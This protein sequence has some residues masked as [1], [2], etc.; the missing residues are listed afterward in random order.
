MCLLTVF[1]FALAD[2]WHSR[3]VTEDNTTWKVQASLNL[4]PSAHVKD[5]SGTANITGT[6]INFNLEAKF[7]AMYVDDEGTHYWNSTW[8]NGK[9]VHVKVW[10]GGNPANDTPTKDWFPSDGDIAEQHAIRFAS[11]HFSDASTPNIVVE[12]KFK[13]WKN[14]PYSQATETITLTLPTLVYNKA[15]TLATLEVFLDEASPPHY[16]KVGDPDFNDPDN[17]VGTAAN[18]ASEG[19]TA[20]TGGA[21][22]NALVPGHANNDT[23][24]RESTSGVPRL[25]EKMCLA[26]IFFACTHG[27]TG[28]YWRSAH[29]DELWF[30]PTTSNEVKTYVTTQLGGSA[31]S[32]TDYVLGFF[33]ACDTL[34]NGPNNPRAFQLSP[35]TPVANKGY[36]GF[37][38]FVRPQLNH[39]SNEYLNEHAKKL[40]E[41]LAAGYPLQRALDRTQNVNGE[42]DGSANYKRAQ[43]RTYSSLKM[44]IR[45]DNY[46]RLVNVYLTKAEYDSLTES[47]RNSWYWVIS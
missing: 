37:T 23:D 19:R 8:E 35:D 25:D 5:V 41:N 9:V 33:Y 21:I 45:G 38:S 22:K 34:A 27:E 7:L 3:T 29:S 12:A 30:S 13:V 10:N 17:V 42:T 44:I 26:N 2:D 16:S 14:S 24:W 46:T 43:N 11:S 40:L 1:N 39:P 31:R 32:V 47:E 18:V 4:T 20:L 28:T 36:V 15:I 6:N